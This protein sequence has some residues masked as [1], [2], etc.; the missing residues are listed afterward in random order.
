[1]TERSAESMRELTFFGGELFCPDFAIIVD[2]DSNASLNEALVV[3]RP[4]CFTEDGM[5]RKDI[6]AELTRIIE[7]NKE[8]IT[9]A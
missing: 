9:N 3:F 2:G 1:M 8:N 5:F 4:E 6:I 7:A